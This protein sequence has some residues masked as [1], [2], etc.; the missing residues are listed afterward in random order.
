MMFDLL[1]HSRRHWRMNGQLVSLELKGGGIIKP[2]ERFPDHCH[3]W[4]LFGGFLEQCYSRDITRPSSYAD[5]FYQKSFS[6]H[7]KWSYNALFLEWFVG[8]WQEARKIGMLPGCWHLYD[9]KSA[10][11]WALKEGLPDT[12]SFRFQR[13]YTYSELHGFNCEGLFVVELEGPKGTYPYPFNRK[14]ERYIATTTEIEKL[15]LPVTKIHAGIT[16]DKSSNVASRMV[17]TILGLPAAKQVGRSYW[18]RWASRAPISCQ[19]ASGK[20]WNLRNVLTNIVWA[21]LILSRVK[22]RVWNQ[23]ANAAHIFVDSVMT[24]DEII[25]GDEIGDWKLVKK[26]NG[27]KIRSPGYYETLDG[28]LIKHAGVSLN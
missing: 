23:S 24:Q 18:G 27:V 15:E 13:S 28:E 22:M 4:N 17:D 6:P 1:P 14:R 19:M 26:F 8:G 7:I 5:L 25:T 2:L 11:L 16:W 10:Y 9:M 3:D 21:H 12:K 20:T